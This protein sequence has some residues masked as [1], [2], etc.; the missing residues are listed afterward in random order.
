MRTRIADL[1][2][3]VAVALLLAVAA[4]FVSCASQREQVRLVDD[5]D[6]HQDSAIPWN[7]QERWENGS[8]FA[9]M[10]DRR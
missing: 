1:K 10:T 3:K 7:K 8:Q 9:N 6:D 4:M 5:P 2:R